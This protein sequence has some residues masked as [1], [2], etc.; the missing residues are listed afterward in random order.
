MKKL[1]AR[2]CCRGDKQVKDVDFFDTF[3]PVVNWTTVRLLL[4]LTAQ[5]DLASTQVDY[6]AAFVHADIDLPPNYE[7][8][9]EEEKSRV[10]VFVEMPRGFAK[11]GYVCKLNKSLY[12]LKQAPRNFFLHLGRIWKLLGSNP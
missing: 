5:L 10:G 1:K 2:W 4:L 8:L 12:G 3:A 7:Q 9:S 11:P 6:T